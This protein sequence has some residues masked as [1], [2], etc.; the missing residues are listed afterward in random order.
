MQLPLRIQVV[1]ELFYRGEETRD[2]SI[3]R[4]GLGIIPGI[5]STRHRESPIKKIAHV[6]ENIGRRARAL[7]KSEFREEFGR[8]TQGFAAAISDRSDGVT[9]KV[10]GWIRRGRHDDSLLSLAFED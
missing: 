9:K 6:G 10:A 3:P 7:P 1:I 8:A 4:Q 5:F 2:L